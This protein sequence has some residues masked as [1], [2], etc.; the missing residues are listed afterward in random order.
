MGMKT[1]DKKEMRKKL[2]EIMK[3]MTKGGRRELGR[4]IKKVEEYRALHPLGEGFPVNN[5]LVHI[6]TDDIQR[7]KFVIEDDLDA[8]VVEVKGSLTREGKREIDKGSGFVY[9][10][11][12]FCPDRSPLL[13]KE[14]LLTED[15]FSTLF[16]NAG[17]VDLD[18]QIFDVETCHVISKKEIVEALAMAIER[19]G[20]PYGIRV[21]RITKRR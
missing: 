12:V 6:I 16:S 2:K 18:Q 20:K 19:A 5:C 21:I 8:Q 3:D 17:F 15:E 14:N 10:F 11:R 4:I 13:A 1:M 9:I 7:C